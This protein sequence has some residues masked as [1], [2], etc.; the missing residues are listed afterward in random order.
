MADLVHKFFTDAF[1]LLLSM[2]PGQPLDQCF[3]LSLKA[4]CWGHCYFWCLS[5]IDQDTVLPTIS[6][7]TNCPSIWGISLMV[8]WTTSNTGCMFAC[9]IFQMN[10]SYLDIQHSEPLTATASLLS[11]P[12]SPSITWL[13]L[14]QTYLSKLKVGTYQLVRLSHLAKRWFSKVQS[15][16]Q[17]QW[18]LTINWNLHNKLEWYFNQNT[19]THSQK[20][21][22]LNVGL[23]VLAL[24]ASILSTICNT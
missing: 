16:Y 10:R 4:L 20:C 18:W 12:T 21:L 1:K 14:P 23:F 6:S 24:S 11:L 13:I 5:D 3:Q 9:R 19:T 22:L 2:A 7:S 17:K 8:Q 15:H